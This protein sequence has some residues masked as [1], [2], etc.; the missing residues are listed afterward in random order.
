MLPEGLEKFSEPVAA[1]VEKPAVPGGH[2]S[3]TVVFETV[4]VVDVVAV[5]VAVVLV[6]VVNVVEVVVV[7][8]TIVI[9]VVVAVVADVVVTVVVVDAAP[10]TP[11]LRWYTIESIVNRSC[12]FQ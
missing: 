7:D 2:K 1:A 9:D 5:A 11:G 8:V 4:D 10:H 3:A 12:G 6:T